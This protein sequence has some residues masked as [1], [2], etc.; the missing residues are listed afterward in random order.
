MCDW[1][2][3]FSQNVCMYYV[4]AKLP[5]LFLAYDTQ[6]LKYDFT[7]LKAFQDNRMQCAR[8]LQAIIYY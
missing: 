7:I 5:G 4:K 6:R 8:G 2:E 1:L 3:S